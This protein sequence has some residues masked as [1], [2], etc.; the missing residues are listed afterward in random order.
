MRIFTIIL[1]LLISCFY[2]LT[3]AQNAPLITAG[4]G[5]SMGNEVNLNISVV[6]FNNI[7]GFSLVLNYDPAIGIA[8][9][10]IPSPLLGGSFEFN[11]SNSGVIIVSW[12][13]TSL[14]G[15]TL[16]DNTALFTLSIYKTGVGTSDLTWIH[17][18]NQCQWYDADFY[19]LNDLPVSNYYSDGA[20]SFLSIQAPKLYISDISNCS[21]QTFQLPVTVSDFN[22]IGYLFLTLNF[23]PQKLTYQSFI[24]E[25]GFPGLSVN[26]ISAGQIVI[27]GSNNSIHGYSIAS[28]QSLLSLSFYNNGIST[29]L[30]WNTGGNSCYFKGPSPSFLLLND[31]PKNVYYFNGDFTALPSPGY[32]SN[33][34]GPENGVVRKGQQNVV[35]SIEPVMYVNTY[36]WSLPQGAV[37]TQGNGSNIIYVSFGLN[38]VS[39][40]LSVQVANECG[41]ISS[42]PFY[43]TV[44]PK[45]TEFGQ[46]D[47]MSLT[48]TLSVPD[49]NLHTMDEYS[50]MNSSNLKTENN[51]INNIDFSGSEINNPDSFDNR[52]EFQ[53]LPQIISVTKQNSQQFKLQFYI[54]AEGRVT[55]HIYNILG[56]ITQIKELPVMPRGFYDE[57]FTVEQQGLYIC[58]VSFITNDYVFT[59]SIKLIQSQ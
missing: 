21:D 50:K 1:A 33:I 10:V 45:I 20:F 7:G 43:V 25:S 17:E 30:N 16:P 44:K 11:T 23:D 39:G 40:N 4:S 41:I 58:S 48:N 36:I 24:N 15:I 42:E 32:I 53:V 14:S 49:P 8:S 59:D 35:F 6:Q 9:S 55:I 37:I 5:V 29:S 28:G 26:E 52:S 51:Q 31:Y 3:Q 34:T 22:N 54:P 38:A 56:A 13:K 19:N 12:F 27:E 18:N 2:N 47:F 57:Y 46:R